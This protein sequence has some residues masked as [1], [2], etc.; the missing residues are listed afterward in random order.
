MVRNK[1]LNVTYHPPPKL[2]QIH[3]LLIPVDAR[4]TP[5]P[6]ISNGTKQC[7][8]LSNHEIT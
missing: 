4:A 1:I 8:V 3:H 2:K 6:K 7:V 5:P